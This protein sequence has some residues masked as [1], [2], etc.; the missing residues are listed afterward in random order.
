MSTD[1]P[2]SKEERKE[3]L[4]LAV[5]NVSG[6]MGSIPMLESTRPKNKKIDAA[7]KLD[8]LKC[9]GEDAD[10]QEPW[11]IADCLT[12]AADGKSA[13]FNVDG[14]IY[15]GAA[16]DFREKVT[17]AGDVKNIFVDI[18]SPGGSFADSVEIFAILAQHPAHVTTRAVADAMSG[19]SII[20]QAGNDRVACSTCTVMVHQVQ[21]TEQEIKDY[22][23]DLSSYLVRVEKANAVLKP[24]YADTNTAGLDE[25]SITA[26]F[27]DGDHF[28]TAD[29]AV[30]QGFADRVEKVER[31]G[32]SSQAMSNQADHG[33]ILGATKIIDSETEIDL[34]SI[35]KFA[36]LG[37][38]AMASKRSK[39]KPKTTKQKSTTASRGGKDGKNKTTPT[40]SDS[41][42]DQVM[43]KW[44]LLQ[45][46]SPQ[47]IKDLTA[48]QRA[49]WERIYNAEIVAP[50]N[51]G[52]I[53][54]AAAGSDDGNMDGGEDIETGI[55][56]RF[57]ARRKLL[58][59]AEEHLS[60]YPTEME[61]AVRENWSPERMENFALKKQNE[62]MTASMGDDI[63]AGKDWMPLT[64]G[65]SSS[66]ANLDDVIECAFSLSLDT[67]VE[68][69]QGGLYK[70][71]DG[72]PMNAV[73]K[74][75]L[76]YTD[77]QSFSDQTIDAAIKFNRGCHNGAIS[78]REMANV[79]LGRNPFSGIN[80]DEDLMVAFSQTK[81]LDWVR[82]A[83]NRQLISGQTESPFVF[84]KFCRVIPNGSFRPTE[85]YKTY[86]MGDLEEVPKGGG[87]HD[88]KFDSA[89]AYKTM[90]KRHAKKFVVD[91]CWFDDGDFGPL[92]E[93]ILKAT[94]TGKRAP[95][96][97]FFA[98][99][100]S[101]LNQAGTMSFTETFLDA[102]WK[103]WCTTTI[104]DSDDPNNKT[105]GTGVYVDG[106]RLAILGSKYDALDWER[107][108][109][110]VAQSVGAGEGTT[111]VTTQNV[112]NIYNKYITFTASP[113]VPGGKFVMMPEGNEQTP[114]F[115]ISYRN[116]V[117]V[118]QAKVF[119]GN[120]SHFGV[121]VRVQHYFNI[122][123][124]DT[125]LVKG[126]ADV[127]AYID[128][129]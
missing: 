2:E 126:V 100:S 82:K 11:N 75:R 99:I 18:N 104:Q 43:D 45:G 10:E 33:L 1:K 81:M 58:A 66:N 129:L 128:A 49:S 39:P 102:I 8:G 29:E 62:E 110:G 67:P 30:A 47:D 65:K 83:T 70:R 121:P 101:W 9:A 3:R 115:A 103:V 7:L 85:R 41:T 6:N 127:Q 4:R 90:L 46:L 117:E 114:A 105:C 72:T 20:L 13:T 122:D 27:A 55:T 109:T 16:A 35:S 57:F 79:A 59:A 5:R 19:G 87:V 63:N 96:T 73:E 51:T 91:E 124:A 15:R 50:A 88:G 61:T 106:A 113:R 40:S 92:R 31:S 64:S 98:L 71:A 86:Y 25:A 36:T 42:G 21:P 54:I 119:P 69:L 111:A 94:E 107:W 17:E 12:V 123:P 56:D 78:V 76:G 26:M 120:E 116:S 118:P 125:G 24:L 52:G 84:R 34:E 93:M 77:L 53:P 38:S 22:I 14:Y 108:L 80:L 89:A 95:E 60:A 23:K 48:A 97:Q 74:S 37:I 44:L 68:T 112:I 32:G 28:M